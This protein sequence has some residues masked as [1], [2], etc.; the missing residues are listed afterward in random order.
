MSAGRPRANSLGRVR[1]EARG[2]RG[3][4]RTDPKA[5]GEL[6]MKEDG[7]ARRGRR[8]GSGSGSEGRK[9]KCVHGCRDREVRK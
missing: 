6:D 5:T 3:S 9:R 7:A 1:A 4:L 2:P 8:T